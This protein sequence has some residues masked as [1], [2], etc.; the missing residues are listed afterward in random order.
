MAQNYMYVNPTKF[1]HC[2]LCCPTDWTP[3][4]CGRHLE[5][6]D[7]C[8]GWTKILSTQVL[9]TPN[10]ASLEDVVSVVSMRMTEETKVPGGRSSNTVQDI[11][12]IEMVRI[13][14]DH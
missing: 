11:I 1:D 9:S 13:D 3:V 6:R 2:T 7:S 8:T 10:E 5:M 12:I 14:V 4:F